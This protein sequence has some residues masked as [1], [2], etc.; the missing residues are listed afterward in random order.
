MKQTEKCLSTFSH[1]HIHIRIFTFSCTPFPI[2]L[3]TFILTHILTFSCTPFPIHVPTSNLM[4]PR[5]QV[6]VCGGGGVGKTTLLRVLSAYA[7]RRTHHTI[8]VDMDT[9]KGAFGV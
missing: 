5:P 3:S 1:F 9:H 2:H 6:C 8:T 7:V 4:S